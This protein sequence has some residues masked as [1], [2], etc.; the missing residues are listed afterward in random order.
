MPHDKPYKIMREFKMYEISAVDTPAQ[1]GAR[2]LIVKR[3]DKPFN[4][5][6]TPS[7]T[8]TSKGNAKMD[9]ELKKQ[10]EELTKKLT[11]QDELNKKLQ[12]KVD[13]LSKV[14]TL[15]ATEAEYFAT[16]NGDAEREAFLAKSSDDR[17]AIVK[18]A[19]DANPVI[20]KDSS[21]NEYRKNDDPRLLKQAKDNDELRKQMGEFIK[22][23]RD[24]K[25][26]KRASAELGN[27]TGK[28]EAKVALLKAIDSIE[29]EEVKKEVNRIIT[30][31]DK[32][33][34]MAF[35]T[36]GTTGGTSDPDDLSDPETQLNKM[37]KD[38]AKVNKVT[39]EQAYDHV[40]Q[41]V[42]G[43][44]VYAEYYRKRHINQ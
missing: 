33:S 32:V 35:K 25:Y 13:L 43:Q 24:A 14:N 2:A 27:L 16:L 4:T 10:I 7:T 22:A 26:E 5:I 30:S 20:Y 9:E 15:S 37:A 6:K 41:S 17:K 18:N 28:M 42:E 36:V 23:G 40:A 34:S 31:I 21:G 11:D 29:D 44:Q 1:E 19:K 12:A 39:Y 3:Y 38:Y 8:S